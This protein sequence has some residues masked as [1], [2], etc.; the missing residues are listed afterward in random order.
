M[1]YYKADDVIEIIANIFKESDIEKSYE[2]NSDDDYKRIAESEIKCFDL[3]TIDI[4]PC[5]ECM[6]AD[7][8]FELVQNIDGTAA[9]LLRWCSNGERKDNE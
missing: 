7:N 9:T 8:C 6:W 1:K 5:E 3:P 2:L 4:V